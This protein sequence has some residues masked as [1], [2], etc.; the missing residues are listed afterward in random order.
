MVS[1]HFV[2]CRWR[3][4]LV[5][6]DVGSGGGGGAG[7]DDNAGGNPAKMR[8]GGQGKRKN[9]FW[10]ARSGAAAG[11]VETTD[12]PDK[13]DPDSGLLGLVQTRF[14][15]EDEMVS[16]HDINSAD[17]WLGRA[18]DME[19]RTK[20]IITMSEINIEEALGPKVDNMQREFKD[21][22]KAIKESMVG[23]KEML[24][25]RSDKSQARASPPG[26]KSSGG[27]R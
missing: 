3:E 17:S 5:E 20:R 25:H 1:H 26:I 23:L 27:H 24:D 11:A 16:T 22:L 13:Y 7:S 4:G 10:T 8:K 15:M 6:E 19:R 21:E 12:E 18:L 9:P 14:H 2:S